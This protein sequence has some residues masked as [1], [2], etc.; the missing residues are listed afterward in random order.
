MHKENPREIP[1]RGKYGSVS[2]SI[3]IESISLFFYFNTKPPH[4]VN[5]LKE[6]C[7]K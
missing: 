1:V 4:V 5:A 6:S 2:Q 3:Q 7:Q